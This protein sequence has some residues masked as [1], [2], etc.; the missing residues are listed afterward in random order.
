MHSSW[1]LKLLS[2]QVQAAKSA[3]LA[4]FDR[5]FKSHRLRL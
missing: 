2:N 3:A 4:L 5:R 1:F